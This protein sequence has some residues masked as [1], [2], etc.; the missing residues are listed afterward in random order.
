MSNAVV[1]VNETTRGT[2][3]LRWRSTHFA[4][5]S[6]RRPMRNRIAKTPT[7]VSSIGTIAN[8]DSGSSVT[9]SRWS[10]CQ[11]IHRIIPSTRATAPT[12]PSTIQLVPT[13]LVGRLAI[14]AAEQEVDEEPAQRTDH[15]SDTEAHRAD[16]ALEHPTPRQQRR[17]QRQEPEQS[18]D[19]EPAIRRA[20]QQRP[21]LRRTHSLTR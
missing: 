1:I 10:F 18:T 11:W 12:M 5:R 19:H 21:R 15:V 8:N 20:E 9:S 2:C 7:V 17:E 4:K 14:G 3:R 6:I 16:Q 13:D